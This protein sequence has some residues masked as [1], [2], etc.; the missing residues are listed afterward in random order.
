MLRSIYSQ[1]HELSR[2]ALD[3]LIPKILQHANPESLHHALHRAAQHQ[4]SLPPIDEGELQELGIRFLSSISHSPDWSNDLSF[5]DKTRQT[6]A[7]LCVLSGFTRLLTKVVDWG[8]DLDVQDVSGLTALHCAYLR[9]DWECVR[10]LKDAGAN[11]SIKDNLGR[12]PRRMCR[13]IG[14]EDMIYSGREAASTPGRLSSAGG[15]DDWVD[16][17][18]T[19]A[20]PENF[21]LPQSS[22]R[23]PNN[24]KA[25]GG[26]HPSAMPILR[27]SSENSF[28]TDDDQWSQEFSRLHISESPPPLSTASPPITDS[29]SGRGGGA[30][31]YGWAHFTLPPS[32]PGAKRNVSGGAPAK[33]HSLPTTST[34]DPQLV[35][36]MPEPTVPSFPVPEPTGNAEESDDYAAPPSREPSSLR[37]SPRM[38]PS[39]RLRHYSPA[40]TPPFRGPYVTRSNVSS[41]PRSPQSLQRPHPSS[42]SAPGGR[43]VSPPGLHSVS[44]KGVAPSLP[45]HLSQREKDEKT[46]IRHQFQ[47]AVRYRMEQQ[48]ATLEKGALADSHAFTRGGEVSMRHFQQSRHEEV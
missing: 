34:F 2:V 47:E 38:T 29:S 35:F 28:S 36:P 23:N 6:I 11:E 12:V 25:G 19:S 9:E 20:S 7:H 16:L 31:R 1:G 27:P 17:S 37:S 32:P 43:Y 48:H 42:P 41:R 18:R 40:Q 13:H 5:A 24:I 46:A 33:F 10:I 21:T 15:E 8:I 3:I 4:A 26:I 14:G 45:P 22:W 39:P 30:P 44:S